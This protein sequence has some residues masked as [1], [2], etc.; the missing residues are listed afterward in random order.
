M[1][2]INAWSLLH[3]PLTLGEEETSECM[4]PP[5][6]APTPDS[7]MFIELSDTRGEDGGL[8]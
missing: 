1:E 7:E 6:P 2:V 3:S 5:L 4:D 8:G